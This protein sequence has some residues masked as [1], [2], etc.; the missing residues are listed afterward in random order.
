[1]RVLLVTL[2]DPET[3]TGGYLYHRRLARRAA[4]HDAELRFA[5]FPERVFPLPVLHR[6]VIRG[7]GA[8]DVV[9]VDS[10]ATAFAAP[11]LG[12][13]RLPPLAAMVHQAPGGIDHGGIRRRVQ[14]EL[15]LRAYRRMTA[16]MAAS[17]ALALDLVR[18]GVAQD[19]VSV[20]A[21][22]RDVAG[23]AEGPPYDLRAGRDAALLCVANWVERKGILAL[24]EALAAVPPPRAVLH[25]VGD[26]RADPGYARRVL[27]RLTEP[28]LAGRVVVHG[29]LSSEQVAGMYAAA[30]AF[31]L[32]STAEP[33]GTVYGEAM[34]AG[35]PVVGVDAGNLPHLA[36]DGVE[37]LIVSPGDVPALA[38]AIAALCERPELR[39]RIAEAARRRAERLPTWDQCARLFFHTLREVAVRRGSASRSSEET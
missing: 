8:A 37:A 17:D 3:L 38:A 30:D 7:A 33:Y 11:W 2:G 35:L 25:L 16:V 15:D 6:A 13:P 12:D 9:V 4:T 23:R 18:A 36:R 22:G 32:P 10:I 28:D 20:V 14:A 39:A 1:M 31:V 34:G 27:R 5:S 24:L 26:Q 21:P 19:K 29:P